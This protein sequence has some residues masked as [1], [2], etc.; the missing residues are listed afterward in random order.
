MLLA[1]ARNGRLENNVLY[2]QETG[3]FCVDITNYNNSL[4]DNVI[5]RKNRLRAKYDAKAFRVGLGEIGDDVVVNKNYLYENQDSEILGIEVNN[6]SGYN[7]AWKTYSYND[8]N[9][10]FEC[11]VYKSNKSIVFFPNNFSN[12]TKRAYTLPDNTIA[13]YAWIKPYVREDNTSMINYLDHTDNLRSREPG[14]CLLLNNASSQYVSFSGGYLSYSS[15]YTVIIYFK[16]EDFGISATYPLFESVTSTSNRNGAYISASDGEVSF[17]Y[18]NG[19]SYTGLISDVNGYN[20]G[21][22]HC[23]AFTCNAGS[24]KM[25]IDGVD[26][27]SSGSIGNLSASQIHRIGYFS[28]GSHYMNGYLSHY[29]AYNRVLSL[30]EIQLFSQQKDKP[31]DWQNLPTN[32]LLWYFPLEDND[33]SNVF[34]ATN[35]NINGILQ[36]Y[37]SGMIYSGNDVPFSYINLKGYGNVYKY[38]G[39]DNYH[40]TILNGDDLPNSGVAEFI[41]TLNSSVGSTGYYSGMQNTGANRFYFGIN[42]SGAGSS[43][44][45]ACIGFQSINGSNLSQGSSSTT[46]VVGKTYGLKVIWNS[47]EATLYINTGSGYSSYRTLTYSGG[48]AS[49]DILIGAFDNN[50]V[51]GNYCPYTIH[52]LEIKDEAGNIIYSTRNGENGYGSPTNS[53][54]IIKVPISI[55]NGAV[56]SN[57]TKPEYWVPLLLI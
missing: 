43:A 11:A 32:E 45:K 1:G 20:D 44:Y 48:F 6:A 51:V 42:G 40:T 21:A 15:T 53:P 14:R 37:S 7:D 10:G 23:A 35:T 26:I 52:L 31:W 18:Y 8:V 54:V 9:N 56:T 47:S 49:R 5:F 25:Y 27:G 30:S 19:S 55:I 24:L 17:G 2:S 22:W 28:N 46:T 3:A 4:T 50:G 34:N 38:N 13:A 41:F 36:N 29:F 16:V 33:T 12:Q 39:S 57:N